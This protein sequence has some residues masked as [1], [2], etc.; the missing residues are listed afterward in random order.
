M[1][2]HSTTRRRFLLTVAGGATLPLLAACGN[3]APSA[4]QAPPVSTPAAATKP[5]SAY[6][7]FIPFTGGAKPDF[8][9]AGPL[10]EDGFSN[11][12]KN[13]Q[14]VL[15]ATA[16][17]GGGKVICYT[18]NSAPAPPT[19]LDQNAAWQEVNKQLN[20]DVQFTI[21]SQADYPTKLQTVMSGNDLPDIML[22]PGGGAAGTTIQ[23]LSQFLG[24]QAADLTPFL[25]GDAAK[26]YPFLAAI[27]TYAWKNSGCV[28]N[29]KLMM[30]PI[31]RYYPGS[32][33][34]KNRHV[35][36]AGI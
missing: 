21:I 7:S 35:Y 4:P 6:P 20:A 10:Y 11:Y 17:G 34:L 9:S 19:P 32:M 25:A 24:A 2:Y 3:I 14:K 31:E 5:T 18:N 27:P 1:L 22:I 15:P 13:P 16:P 12:P 29:S 33:L 26:D 36:D 8:P 28:R 30:L 23:N